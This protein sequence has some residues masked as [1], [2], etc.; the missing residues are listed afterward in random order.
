MGH[1][2]QQS[3]QDP[4]RS[5][6]PAPKTA[7]KCPSGKAEFLFTLYTCIANKHILISFETCGTIH[8]VA[9][10]Q[11]QSSHHVKNTF[12]VYLCACMCPSAYV[13]GCMEERNWHVRMHVSCNA[14]WLYFRSCNVFNQIIL[15]YIRISKEPKVAFNPL[16]LD[17]CKCRGQ[18]SICMF[19]FHRANSKE[20]QC[21][22]DF[23][24]CD[25]VLFCPWSYSA[26]GFIITCLIGA[27][28]FIVDQSTWTWVM[29]GLPNDGYLIVHIW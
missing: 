12:F 13:S 2:G 8:H 20:Y 17:I 9:W 24:N 11:T 21:S 23:T 6:F 28:H 25:S 3:R 27:R 18:L 26:M 7:C 4:F 19:L 1:R 5:G 14:Q 29:K 22:A 16:S 15:W 10:S